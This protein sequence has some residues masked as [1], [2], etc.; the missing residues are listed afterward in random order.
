MVEPA[1]A[2]KA[3]QRANAEDIALL[4]QSVADLKDSKRD[5]IKLVASDLMFHRAIFQA[6]GNRLTERLFHT[7]HKGM[8]NMIM[9]TSEM[10]DLEHTLQFH[11][12]ILAAIE[13]RDSRLA[14]D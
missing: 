8:L 10:V 1:L 13:Q 12:P 3:A 11:V 14:G 2:A 4:R 9:M 7:L 5:R 6:C